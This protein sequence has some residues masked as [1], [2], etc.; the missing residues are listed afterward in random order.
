MSPSDTVGQVVV[1][2][3]TERARYEVSFAGSPAGFADYILTDAMITFTHTEIDPAFEGKGLGS[4]LV[5]AALDDV[6]SVGGRK[7]LPVCPFF[8][9]WILR[10]RDYQD[11]LYR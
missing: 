9:A 3:N 8:K 7:V 5:R 2:N 4:A 10:H 6:R 1:T 11:L